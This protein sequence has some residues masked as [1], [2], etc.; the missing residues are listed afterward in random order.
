[1]MKMTVALCQHHNILYHDVGMTGTLMCV[2]L[3]PWHAM[4]MTMEWWGCDD[5]DIMMAV[6]VQLYLHHQTQ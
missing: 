2:R 5:N 3:H 1:M 4:A 6:C